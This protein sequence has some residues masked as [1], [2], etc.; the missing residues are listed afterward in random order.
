MRE[1]QAMRFGPDVKATYG[2][3]WKEIYY[4]A[5]IIVRNKLRTVEPREVE[6]IL[7]PD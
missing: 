7:P 5:D 6:K 2:P 4:Q 1:I 3:H